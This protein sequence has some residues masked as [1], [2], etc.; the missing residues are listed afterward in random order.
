MK[1]MKVSSSLGEGMICVSHWHL[2]EAVQEVVYTMAENL[3]LFW[4][5]I[6]SQS[7]ENGEQAI[8]HDWHIVTLLPGI[9][10][11]V[12]LYWWLLLL[13]YLTYVSSLLLLH[14]LLHL[15]A[16]F[17]LPHLHMCLYSILYYSSCAGPNQEMIYDF[18]RMVWQENCFSIVMLTKLVEIGRVSFSS[19]LC[20]LFSSA[21]L[22]R[23]MESLF[24]WS[25]LDVRCAAALWFGEQMGAI[26]WSWLM[27]CYFGG[28]RSR[29]QLWCLY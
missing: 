21:Y 2:R 7:E 13:F 20:S 1:S 14:P 29:S 3:W 15:S 27:S 4:N 18:W 16:F 28:C 6:S 26:V 22:W 19:F 25:S 24:F 10:Y 5:D 9:D 23:W 11:T 17:S 8:A 12:P